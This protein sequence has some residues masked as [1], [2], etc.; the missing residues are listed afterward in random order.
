MSLLTRLLASPPK[1]SLSFV[2]ILDKYVSSEH[3][4]LS[5]AFDSVIVFREAL[6]GMW[7][8]WMKSSERVSC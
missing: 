3:S 4:G 1:L 6:S 7:E 5:E 8:E 2:N